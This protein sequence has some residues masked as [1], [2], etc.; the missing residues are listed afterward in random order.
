MK[1]TAFRARVTLRAALTTTLVLLIAT[2]AACGGTKVYTIDKTM[3]YRD[4]LYNMSS[5]ATIKPREEASLAN[6]EVVSLRGKEKGELQ[7]FFKE[8]PDVMVSMIVDLDDQEMVYL[9]S[10]VKNYSEYSR[11]SKR[12]EGAFKDINK[13]MADKKDTQLKLK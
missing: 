5:V 7:S 2:L 3:T 11:M 1:S 9:R 10:R 6:G 8:N 4:A 13:F 12:F